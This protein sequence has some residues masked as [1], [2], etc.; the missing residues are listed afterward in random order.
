MKKQTISLWKS[1]NFWDKI[2]LLLGTIGI[3]GEVTLFIVESY[4]KWKVV[5]A[6]STVASIAITY[7][8]KDNNKNGIID[9]VE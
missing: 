8:F 2:R 7:I 6:A 1:V 4:P 9:I 5:A 3:G